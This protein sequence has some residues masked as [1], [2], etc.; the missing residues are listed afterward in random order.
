MSLNFPSAKELRKH[1]KKHWREFDLA[2]ETAVTEYLALARAFCDGPCPL[3]TDECTRTCDTKIDRFR[4]PRGEF[5]VLMPD[6]SVILTFHILHPRGTVGVQI[7]RT[8]RFDTNRQYFE[9][10][11]E[12]LT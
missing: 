10:D 9:A 12:C 11:C 1:T 5:A 6:R 7:E 3:G 4:E 2:N 8:H